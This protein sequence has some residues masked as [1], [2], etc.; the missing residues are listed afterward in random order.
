MSTFNRRLV[1]GDDLRHAPDL[2]GDIPPEYFHTIQTFPG[3][4]GVGRISTRAI[5]RALDLALGMDNTR[6]LLAGN[7][8][9]V[10]MTA[11]PIIEAHIRQSSYMPNKDLQADLMT[12]IL[13]ECAHTAG[14]PE[15][16]E[17]RMSYVR[18]VLDDMSFGAEFS[19]HVYNQLLMNNAILIPWVL[20]NVYPGC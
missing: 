6:K 4:A 1:S 11:G 12:N 10:I 14:V 17:D 7:T 13:K 9:I 5:I 16:V 2:P 8:P 3:L 15:T 20:T 19:Q 18:K